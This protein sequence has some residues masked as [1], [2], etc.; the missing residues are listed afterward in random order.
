[1]PTH[2]ASRSASGGAPLSGAL[3]APERAAHD[4]VGVDAR[5]A[6]AARLL[7]DVVDEGDYREVVLA[8][9]VPRLLD[10]VVFPEKT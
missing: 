9:L 7:D 4:P 10:L 8:A 5:H 2:Q 6:V 3:V 1:M